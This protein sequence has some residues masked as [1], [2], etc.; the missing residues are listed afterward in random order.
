MARTKATT[1]KTANNVVKKAKKSSCAPQH[2]LKLIKNDPYLE[3]FTDAIN[4]RYQAAINKKIELV[5]EKGNLNDFASGYLY[6]GLH[7]TE[8]TWIL[9]E[10]A[11]NAIDIFVVG[12]FNDWKE[13]AK[14]AMKRI[15]GTGNWEIKI[16]NKNF[17]HGTHFKLIVHWDGGCGERIPAWA[18]RVVQDPESHLF[19]AQVWDPEEK[20]EWSNTKF[21]PETD[22]LLIYECHIGMGQDAEK[23]G[24]YTEFRDNVL[25]RVAKLGYNCIQIMAIQE[26]PYYG[27]F[28]YH[29]SSFFAASSRFGTPEELKSLI[30]TAHSKGIAVIMDIVHSHAVKNENE[31]LGNFAGDPNQY[32]YQGALH[33]HPAWDSLC[34]DY[35]KNEVIHFLLSNCK[36][37]L[38]EFHFDG[39][40]FDGVTSMLYYSH[41][42][43]ESFCEY[44]DYYNGH[45]D[46]NAITYLTLANDLI[47]Q[48]NKHAITIAEEVSGMPGIA[49]PIK[50]G[51]YGFDYRM[52][53]NI[54][55]Y[56][57]K[58]I[59]ELK[60]EDWKPSSMLWELTNR[61]KDEKTISY[62]ECH[63]QAL[64][65]DKTIIFRLID[66]DMYWHFK[67]GDQTSTVERG[68][69]LHKMI[70]L[71]TAST[72]NGGYLNFMG[73]E[74]GHPEWI[75]FPREGNGWSYKY[76]RRQWNLV[77]DKSLCYHYLNDFDI[78][79][80][81]LIK[82]QKHF[83]KQPVQ[84]IWHNDGDQVFAYQRGDLLFFFNFSPTRSYCGY[85][86]MVKQGSYE[87][88]LNTDDVAFGGNGF[89]DDKITHLTNYDNVLA[90][91]NKGWLQLYLPART[92]C[93]LKKTKE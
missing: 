79:M 39:F 85:G 43:G 50:D 82:K 68:I 20:Y 88:L 30:D 42:L 5:G 57:I 15:K 35:G 21:K 1:K 67:K 76:A 51:G 56:W 9:R 70:R 71:L 28:G 59:K 22:P 19:S 89:N 10:W 4:G 34:F 73:N 75:D 40:R 60:D 80:L 11:P 14:Y 53:M 27:S 93:V 61:R 77:D 49:A 55:D 25:P 52:A 87:Y 38:E 26:H 64:V 90:R 54:P 33:E 6:F 16:K 8:D 17:R 58:T 44:G 62:A 72:I 48:V 86:F 23:V 3:P 92:A 31:G 81:K 41:G 84:E 13:S 12:D 83:E 47:H 46:G 69:A 36:Y 18:T 7:K 29:V 2:Q 65:G 24:T 37:W 78:S 63:D 66:A 74:F 91:D 32:F 45:Q